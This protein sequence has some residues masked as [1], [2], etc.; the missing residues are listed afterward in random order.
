MN[1]NTDWHVIFLTVSFVFLP[2]LQFCLNFTQCFNL[3]PCQI[4]SLPLVLLLSRLPFPNA[5]R[6]SRSSS[7]L[8]SL[9]HF[10][11]HCST[12]WFFLC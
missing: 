11:S 8:Y 3:I 7:F 2:S 9:T 5:L 1:Y 12:Y 4:Y 10:V 6:I